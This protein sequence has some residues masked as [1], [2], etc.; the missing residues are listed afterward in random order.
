MY[1]EHPTNKLQFRV[2]EWFMQQVSQPFLQTSMF[3]DNNLLSSFGGL[4]PTGNFQ[5][6]DPK[7]GQFWRPACSSGCA[8]TCL[9]TKQQ[10]ASFSV[11]GLPN[12]M[13][14]DNFMCTCICHT[15][16]D[17]FKH[18]PETLITVLNSPSIHTQIYR[19]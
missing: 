10:A 4:I 6:G 3:Y 15:S 13:C 7:K 14:R 2:V 9:I 17:P 16:P 12:L 18:I 1:G 5:E 19:G 11:F 8:F